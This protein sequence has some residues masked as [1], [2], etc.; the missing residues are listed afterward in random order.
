MAAGSKEKSGTKPRTSAGSSGRKR[1]RQKARPS[2]GG[3]K[4]A[5]GVGTQLTTPT[6]MDAIAPIAGTTP[7]ID[8]R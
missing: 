1:A 2:S 6:P 4:R 8:G 7:T 3:A 5:R